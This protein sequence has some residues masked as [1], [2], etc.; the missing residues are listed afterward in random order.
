MPEIE[1]I[2]VIIFREVKRIR[3]SKINLA[4]STS[5][6]VEHIFISRLKTKEHRSYNSI[7]PIL[8]SERGQSSLLSMATGERERLSSGTN[9]S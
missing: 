7:P 9:Q 2:E 4:Q 1:V 6:D 8:S 3:R 5:I